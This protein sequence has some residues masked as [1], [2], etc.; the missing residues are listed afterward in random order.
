MSKES[1]MSMLSG[2]PIAPPPSITPESIAPVQSETVQLQSTPFNHLAKKEAE[3]VRQR[4]QLKKEQELH[5]IERNKLLEVKKQ[6]D[7]YQEKKKTDPVSALKMLGFSEADIFNYMANQQPVELTPE[8]KAAQAAEQAA[9]ARIKA[10]E[11]GQLKKEKEAQQAQ[12]QSL[13]QGF[14]GE[15]SN[16]IQK[17]AEKY[18]YCAY[19]G[20]EAEALAYEITLAVVKESNG[21]DVITAEEAIQ[22]AEEYF[23]E[24][25]REMS[26]LKKRQPRAP[27]APQKTDQTRTRTLSTPPKTDQPKPTIT[28]SRTLHNGATS[29]VAATRLTRNETKEQKRDRLIS[30]LREGAKL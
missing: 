10:F 6:Y 12:D 19:Y 27:E 8:Q 2:N 1:A 29:T 13:I 15:I 4:E 5:S 28:H 16:A 17:N 11:E 7:D 23:E 18:E 14:K 30:A 25:D 20:P 21:N 3:I 24:K 22:M 26:G 9:E